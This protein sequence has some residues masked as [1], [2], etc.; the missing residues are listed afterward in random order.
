MQEPES[1]A[2]M[3]K[4]KCYTPCPDLQWPAHNELSQ[5]TVASRPQL[6]SGVRSGVGMAV[7]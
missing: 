5:L 1:G 4:A 3:L 7:A 2:P 6:N